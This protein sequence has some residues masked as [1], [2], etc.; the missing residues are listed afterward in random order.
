MTVVVMALGAFSCKEKS[1]Q[2]SLDQNILYRGN[3]GEP[4]SLDPH[5]VSGTWENNIV[6]DLFVGLL[7]EAADGT[8]IAGAA[9]SWEVS[10][11]G[12]TYTF[13]LR[14]DGQW[15]DGKPVTAEDFVFSFRRA[16]DP[17]LA[18]RYANILYPIKN[19]QALNTTKITGMEKLGIKALDDYTLEIT[20][21]ASTPYFLGLLTNFTAFPIPKHIVEQFDK[22]WIKAE[23]IASNGAYKLLEWKSQSYV[24]IVKNDFFYDADNVQ[25]EEVY[26]YPTED[27]ASAL[28]RFRAGEL[29]INSNFPLEQYQWLKEN[30]PNETKVFPQQGIY[31]YVINHRLKK[32]QDKRVREALALSVDLDTLVNKI[33][34]SG[35]VQAT[36]FVP[37]LANY[38]QATFSFKEMSMD[39]RLERAKK[40]LQEA[41]YSQENPLTI[42]IRYNTSESHKKIAVAIAAM[43]KEIG[44][45]TKL[46]NLEVAVHFSEMALGKFEIGR[47]GWIAEY[48]DAQAI[49]RLLLPNK[50]NSGQYQNEKFNQKMQEASVTLDL[51]KRAQIMQEA[52]QIVLDDFAVIPIYY[53]VSTNLVSSHITGWQVNSRDVHR[54]RWMSKE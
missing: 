23:N 1:P 53:Y 6:G 16:L 39:E 36:G 24:K 31:Y 4:G 12:K 38:Q 29:D 14:K 30:M 49:L 3:G 35:A 51:K 2:K 32:F 34:Q 42:E 37:P 27:A 22:D 54:T 17:K 19:A 8:A 52:E 45:K 47:R 11:D 40:L 46:F 20:L 48:S 41:G 7:T 9:K 18:A 21:E 33:I 5:L 28:K 26:Y 10:A 13:H 15:S 43:W 50:L 25:I 44:I